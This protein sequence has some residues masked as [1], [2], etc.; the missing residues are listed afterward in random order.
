MNFAVHIVV[1]IVK[2]D[3]I[4]AFGKKPFVDEK[5]V[6]EAVVLV[7]Q[8]TVEHIVAVEKLVVVE[9]LLLRWG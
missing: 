7:T 8:F 5:I 9:I 3:N 1:P 6:A 2:K 4:A